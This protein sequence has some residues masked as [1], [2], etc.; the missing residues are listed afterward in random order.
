[1]AENESSRFKMRTDDEKPDFPAKEELDDLRFEKLKKRITR[2]SIF[3]T[4]LIGVVILFTYLDLK[5]SISITDS[6]GTMGVKTLSKELESKYSSLSVR[7]ANLEDTLKKRVDAIEKSAASIQ[8]NLNKATTAIKYI[9]SARKA[10]NKKIESAITTIEKRLSPLPND[11]ANLTSELKNIDHAFN[12]KLENLSQTVGSTKT[13]LVSIRS[14][15]DILKSAKIDQKTINILLKNQQQTYQLALKK[16]TSNFEDRIKSFEKKLK[17][18]EKIE[19][20]PK[21]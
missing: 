20:L 13:N 15:I 17:E 6:T 10:D 7:Q 18:L 5:K 21:N 4:C 16:I 12:K 11:L 1:M 14:D 8:A 9:R 19:K 3:I 2:I